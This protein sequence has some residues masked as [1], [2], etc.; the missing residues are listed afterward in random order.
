M[1]PVGSVTI[2]FLR[3][4]RAPPRV[5]PQIVL[6]VSVVRWHARLRAIAIARRPRSTRKDT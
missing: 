2:R 4:V 1:D 3:E 5:L 6:D